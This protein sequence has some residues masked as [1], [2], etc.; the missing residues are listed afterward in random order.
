M[1][2]EPHIVE[3]EKPKRSQLP[4]ALG[5][6]TVI[7]I[8]MTVISVSIYNL[9]GFYKLDLSRPGYETERG[10]IENTIEEPYDTTS[11]LTKEALDDVLHTLDSRVEN[12]KSYGD[13]RS[14]ALNDENLLLTE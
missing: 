5:I 9:A 12:L 4:L 11:P 2:P 14:D 8:I 10:D 1:T 13:F 3:V 6:A 7:A